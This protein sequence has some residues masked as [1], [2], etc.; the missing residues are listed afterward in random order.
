MFSFL[1]PPPLVLKAPLSLAGLVFFCFYL[2]SFSLPAGAQQNASPKAIAVLRGLNKITARVRELEIPVGGGGHFGSLHIEVRA[3]YKTPADEAPESVA[4][5][6]I[7]DQEAPQEE[8][9]K[10]SGWMYASSPGL[11]TLEHPVY[12]VWALDCR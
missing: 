7:Y 9:L 8:Q 4:F 5:V 10:F 6:K 1:R 3:C 12:S 11:S 2:M